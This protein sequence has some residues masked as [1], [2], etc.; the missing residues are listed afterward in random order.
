MVEK[1]AL[2]CKALVEKFIVSSKRFP[3]TI[4]L[5]TSIVIILCVI[6]HQ[7]S[8]LSNEI[9]DLWYRISMILGLGIPLS[10]SIKVFL[11]RRPLLKVS[12]KAMIY[13]ITIIGL[14]LYY[15]FL[16]KDI[17]IT[18]VIR[19]VAVNISFYCVFLFLPQKENY[20][21]YIINLISRFFV[22]YLYSVILYAGLAAMLGTIH[23]LF[24]INISNNLYLDIWLI[25][26]GIF[27]PVFFLGDI[28]RQKEELTLSFYPK[29]LNILLLYIIMPLLVAYSITLYIYFA[30]ILITMQWPEGIV[31]NLVLWYSLICITVIFAIYPLRDVNRWARNFIRWF[32]IVVLPLLA[33]MFV[34]LGMRIQAYGI[35]ENRY[36]PL[37]T[38]LWL[39]GCM[40]YFIVIKMPRTLVLT[41]SIAI[42]SFL[43]VM[44]PWS[45]FSLST[46]SQSMRFERI[47]SKY[48]IVENGRISKIPR[49]V[50]PEDRKEI[51]NIISYFNQYKK[52][53]ALNSLPQDFKI[54]QMKTT[55]GFT[56]TGENGVHFRHTTKEQN[57]VMDIRGF[58]YFLQLPSVD[59]TKQKADSPISVSYMGKNREVK[60]MNMDQVIYVGNINDIAIKI[61]NANKGTESLKNEEMRFIDQNEMVKVVYVFKGIAGMDEDE[62]ISIREAN[63]S[64]LI[65]LMR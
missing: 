48:D 10:L 56:V 37:L 24:L 60:I 8:T 9:L 46:A 32:P 65:K 19:Y 39:M 40:I 41:I 55:F 27:A 29:V 54:E 14:W 47:I 25:V 43:S 63:V 11:E 50:S 49:E 13:G 18:A 64:L 17:H 61:H 36:F 1:V 12:T 45:C 3:E 28:P 62:T 38:G 58:D 7:S 34:A 53:G 42:L 5:S 22:T 23:A 31:S 2:F 33:M 26:A 4:F 35:T 30:K 6:N 21:L 20:E 15:N 57:D 59:I 16:L 52:L 51:G 44:G